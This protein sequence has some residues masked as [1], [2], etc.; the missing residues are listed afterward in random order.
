MKQVVE[1]VFCSFSSAVQ[2]LWLT[3]D[4]NHASEVVSRQSTVEK[5]E[6]GRPC[7]S[8]HYPTITS[9]G[10]VQNGCVSS[11][12]EKEACRYICM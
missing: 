7:G 11:G 2:S 4:Y 12:E 9:K 5:V 8:C 6:E 1:S 3:P 10:L